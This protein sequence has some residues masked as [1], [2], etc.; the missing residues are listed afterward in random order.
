MYEIRSKCNSCGHEETRKI[1][2][3]KFEKIQI[4]QHTCYNN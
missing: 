4:S 1:P 3:V 2:G